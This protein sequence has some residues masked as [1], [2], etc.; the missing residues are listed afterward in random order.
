[1]SL[2]ITDDEFLSPKLSCI[3]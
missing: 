1:M 2:Y 3:T